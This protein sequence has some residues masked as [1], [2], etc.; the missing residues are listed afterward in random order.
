MSGPIC[1]DNSS[2]KQ[3][4]SAWARLH[5]SN[6]RLDFFDDDSLAEAKA[7]PI[8]SIDLREKVRSNIES[9]FLLL[10]AS[11]KVTGEKEKREKVQSEALQWRMAESVAPGVDEEGRQMSCVH[12]MTER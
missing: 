9:L 6:G 7:Q 1:R 2:K 10:F 4:A 3:W 8:L 5:D 11:R 12:I